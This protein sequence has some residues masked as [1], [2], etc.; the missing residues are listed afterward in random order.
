MLDHAVPGGRDEGLAGDLLEE[1]RA[2][3]SEGWYW[4]Q[5]L[6]ACALGWLSNFN[7]NRNLLVF[8]VL[9]SALA[10]AWTMLIDR[11]ENNASLFGQ[12]WRMDFPFSSLTRFAVWMGCNLA[13]L[14]TG[15][16]LYLL[17]HAVHRKALSKHR[18]RRAILVP[19][20]MFNAT[21]VG[22]FVLMN[23]LAYPGPVVDRRTVTALGEIIDVRQWAMVLRLPYFLT[24]VCALW[25]TRGF[26]TGGFTP[27]VQLA[28]NGPSATSPAA[29]AELQADP[30]SVA[31]HLGFFAGAGLL[32]SII[33]A[34]LLCRL[35]ESNTPSWTM[36]MVRAI[37][38][39]L[40]GALAGV[41]GAWFYWK[42]SSAGDQLTPLISFRRF[43]LVC[44][45]S[46]I[47]VPA[48]VLLAAQESSFAVGIAGLGGAILA[49]GLR[50]NI[51]LVDGPRR[52][53]A[54]FSEKEMF[55][56]SLSTPAGRPQGYVIALCVFAGA[57]ALC[58][59]S[60]AA[61]CALLAFAAFVFVWE[62]ILSPSRSRAGW[63]NRH[64]ALRLARIA[65]VAVLVTAWA[66]LDGVDH[67]NVAVANGGVFAGANERASKRAVNVLDP[68]SDLSGYESIVL[69]P[70]PEKKQI[71]PPL[72]ARPNLLAPGTFKP[73]IIRFDG[74]YFYFQ[75]GRRPDSASH[76]AQGTPLAVHIEASNSIPLSIEARQTLSTAIPIARC[77]E[78]AVDI[79]NRDN[80]PGLIAMA[81][82]LR[83]S[84]NPRKQGLYLGEQPIES[85]QPMQFT[86]KSAPVFET[87][88]FAVPAHASLRAFDEITVM[89]LPDVNHALV[90]PKIAIR[91]FQLMPR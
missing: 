21:Y 41:T 24:I 68:A 70:V 86:F 78:M 83:D 69:W 80:Q 81:V 75:A 88:R 9:W 53:D 65:L 87:L 77:R 50:K 79:Q 34:V 76:Q 11:V 54:D 4:R 8:A 45:A 61:A 84:S 71:I 48:I 6:S 5:T 30:R 37:V 72:P 29:S 74:P 32:N 14:W 42:R 91:D 63:G 1:F 55:V 25:K 2:G 60:T 31:G 56:E 3:R 44:A 28:Q 12:M 67:R 26:A 10:P 66:L 85:T 89:L 57:W 38:Y 19:L 62:L 17:P 33:V 18:I 43:A 40:L 20:V 22:M 15:M 90:G 82:L 36:V 27:A 52:D 35:P 59:R 49:I 13:F 47:W 58:D 51:P 7:E 16:L 39:V 23:L 73:L 46:W 64:A